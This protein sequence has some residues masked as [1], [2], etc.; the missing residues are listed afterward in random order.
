MRDV[1]Q[2]VP[3]PVPAAGS[4]SPQSCGLRTV[5]SVVILLYIIAA[6]GK[7]DEIL[8]TRQATT[9]I[10]GFIFKSKLKIVGTCTSPVGCQYSSGSYW[11]S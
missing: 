10:L 2:R 8:K 4:K 11:I 6:I 7:G 9:K 5:S 1:H 3:E